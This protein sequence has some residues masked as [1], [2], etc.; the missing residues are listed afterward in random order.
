V[1]HAT[2]NAIIVIFVPVSLTGLDKLPR[3]K[4]VEL[5]GLRQ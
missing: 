1:D 3:L 2:D 4:V 5:K